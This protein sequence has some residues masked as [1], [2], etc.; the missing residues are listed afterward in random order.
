MPYYY[1]AADVTVERRAWAADNSHVVDESSSPL[2]HCQDVHADTLADLLA[3]VESAIVAAGHT[4]T[5]PRKP[6]KT[7]WHL[8]D[9]EAGGW[10]IDIDGARCAGC[11]DLVTVRITYAGPVTGWVA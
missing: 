3:Q 10:A 7:R 4:L 9:E 1:T 11:E 6:A 5:Y 2:E 8:F